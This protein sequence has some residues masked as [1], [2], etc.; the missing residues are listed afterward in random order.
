[1]RKKDENLQRE[2][3]NLAKE[4]ADTWG[5]DS[6]TIRAVAKKAGIAT[7]TVYNYFLSK[8][9][10]LL[11][12]TE[13]YWR[14][15]LLEMHGEIKAENFCDQ[16]EEIYL[17]LSQRIHQSAGML[18]GSL[19]NVEMVG[20]ERMQAMQI[21]L[22]KILV[23]RMEK[24]H[25]IDDNIW[26]ESFTKEQYVRFIIMNLMLLLRTKSQDIQFFIQIIRRTLY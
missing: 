14:S 12:L 26:S 6:I 13:E 18:M 5:P 25:A 17:F 10:I 2:L 16:L 7:G 20:R 24:D 21:K 9:D 8:D 3:L 23:Q 15:T 1:M 22:G 11:A 19:H 4:M